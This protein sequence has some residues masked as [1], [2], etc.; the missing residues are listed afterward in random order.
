MP[1][2]CEEGDCATQL[3]LKFDSAE[4]AEKIANSP[5]VRMVIPFYLGKHVY[6]DWEPIMNKRGAAHPLMNPYEMEINKGVEYSPDMCQKSLEILK[7]AGH[8][9]INPDWTDEEIEAVAE[10]FIEAAKNR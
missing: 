9:N 10:I 4:E 6:H 5:G 2:N 1:L 7:K 3:A 8:I